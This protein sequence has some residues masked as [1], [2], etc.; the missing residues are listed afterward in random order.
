MGRGF[1]KSC[2]WVRTPAMGSGA[3]CAA[4]RRLTAAYQLLPRKIKIVLSRDLPEELDLSAQDRVYAD[5]EC[6]FEGGAR[7][8]VAV[9]T[10]PDWK[11]FES[12]PVFLKPGRNRVFFDLRA[13]TWKTGEQVPEGQTE[14]CRRIAN[15]DAVRRMTLLLY[16]IQPEGAVS[17]DRIEFRAK[18]R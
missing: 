8:S 2:G 1:A 11:Y 15:P 10:M 4:G 14:F 18:P 17:L 5:L 13:P 16:P 9:S 3:R 7:L 12:R 6:R